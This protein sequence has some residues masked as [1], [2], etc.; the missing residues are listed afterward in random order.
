MTRMPVFVQR[1]PQLHCT[2]RTVST[3]RVNLTVTP[4]TTAGSRSKEKERISAKVTLDLG[5]DFL[6]IRINELY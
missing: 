2:F 6:S 5:K 4:L 3:S 1:K